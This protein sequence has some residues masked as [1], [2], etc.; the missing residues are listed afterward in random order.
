MPFRHR[1]SVQDRLAGVP[2]VVSLDVA[3]FGLD[4]KNLAGEGRLTIP[5]GRFDDAP[6]WDVLGLVGED[7]PTMSRSRSGMARFFLTAAG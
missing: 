1:I 3:G 7:Q 4:P 6:L 2:G 5:E